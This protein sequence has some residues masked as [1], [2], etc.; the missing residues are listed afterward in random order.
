VIRSD[1]PPAALIA[2]TRA[3]IREFDP[4]LSVGRVRTM[5]AILDSSIDREKM[6]A[7]LLLSAAAVSVFL[8]AIGV[9]GVAAHAARRREQELGIRASLGAR[10]GQLVTMVLRQAAG[11]I[12]A[13]AVLGVA[14]T[15]IAARALQSFLFEVSA[16]DPTTVATVTALLVAV[17]L[18]A[19][20]MPVRRTVV[21]D[22][23][24]AL[25]SN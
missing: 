12:A 11:F 15:L 22:P 1:V 14:T 16:T 18:A 17:A 19:I 21:R 9:Y 5:E 4:T 6:L 8:G 10:P 13:G 7:V 25:R 3:A 2:A 24:A 23:I 20:V